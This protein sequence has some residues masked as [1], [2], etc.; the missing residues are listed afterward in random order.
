MN[1]GKCTAWNLFN[2]LDI[3]VCL[4]LILH[5]RQLLLLHIKLL[6]LLHIKLVVVAHKIVVSSHKI[7]VVVVD[8][9]MLLIAT[10]ASHKTIDA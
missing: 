9:K 4:L 6:L 2:G 3:I 10:V 1:R 8:I 7:I 5:I